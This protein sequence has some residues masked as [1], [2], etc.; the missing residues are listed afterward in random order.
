MFA[1]IYMP[2]LTMVQTEEYIL[3]L[4]PGHCREL[5][6]H[7]WSIPHEI[8][9]WIPDKR[10]QGHNTPLAITLRLLKYNS[11]GKFP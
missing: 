8:A 9:P 4:F 5:H 10:G 3:C 6:S 2:L 7:D 1:R 11:N